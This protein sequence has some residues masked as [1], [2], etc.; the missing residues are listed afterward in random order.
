M[1]PVREVAIMASVLLPGDVGV[2]AAGAAAMTSATG[3][4]G[5]GAAGSSASAPPELD[6][7]ALGTLSSSA[8]SKMKRQQQQARKGTW[9]HGKHPPSSQPPLRHWSK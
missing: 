2:G 5:S 9:R 8:L 7:E 1:T 3:L 6:A 4:S